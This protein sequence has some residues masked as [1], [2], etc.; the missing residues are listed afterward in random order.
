MIPVV[1]EQR[2][3]EAPCRLTIAF[4]SDL[5]IRKSMNVD[6]IAAIIQSAN[7]DALIL[8]GDI[9]DCEPDARRMLRAISALSFPHGKY[10]V[11]GNNDIEAFGSAKRFGSALADEGIK[12]LENEGILI[13]ES[14]AF[15]VGAAD[16]K[17]GKPNPRRAFA[18]A[19][20]RA[21]RILASHYPLEEMLECA[22]DLMLSGH[23]HGGQFNLFG[24][25]PYTF[26]YEK[27]LRLARIAG[28][29]K[30]GR[31]R[32]L[33][34]RGVGASKMPLRIGVRSEVHRIVLGG[35]MMENN[36]R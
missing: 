9:A 10:A 7:A 25:T 26:G 28:T 36:P 18:N 2:F 31:T 23:T 14:N 32:I 30:R 27:K 4:A 13:P 17:Y 11:C 16:A 20:E 29:E 5:H 24:I 6:A 15:L 34:S 8:G 1:D 22:P 35:E 3:P 21:Y 12:L 19:P 33:V